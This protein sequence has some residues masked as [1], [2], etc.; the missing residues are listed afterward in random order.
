MVGD[1][2]IK[3]IIDPDGK[4]QRLLQRKTTDFREIGFVNGLIMDPNDIRWGSQEIYEG[5]YGPL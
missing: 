1:E 4:K 3:N 2:T 5:R